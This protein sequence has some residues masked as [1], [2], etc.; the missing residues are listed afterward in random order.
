MDLSTAMESCINKC[1]VS[2]T[3]KCD[4]CTAAYCSDCMTNRKCFYM[5]HCE[6]CNVIMWICCKYCQ[7]PKQWCRLPPQAKFHLAKERIFINHFFL[8]VKEKG[9]F[10]CQY[11]K[12][13]IPGI[14][15]DDFKNHQV[16]CEKNFLQPIYTTPSRESMQ[17]ITT[18]LIS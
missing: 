15:F 13:N 3:R 17:P 18:C 10:K 7:P 8:S 14:H 16:V 4:I 2:Y 9:Y 11:C 12:R 5:K 6:I 1:Q